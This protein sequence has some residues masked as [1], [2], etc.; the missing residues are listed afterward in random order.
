MMAIDQDLVDGIVLEARSFY[1]RN[2]CEGV[3]LLNCDEVYWN[4]LSGKLMA[5][6]IPAFREGYEV[7]DGLTLQEIDMARYLS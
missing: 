6:F 4:V 5:H 1:E 3:L 7:H 2:E